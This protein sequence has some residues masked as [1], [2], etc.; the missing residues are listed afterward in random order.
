MTSPYILV[1]AASIT[2]AEPYIAEITNRGGKIQ[3]ALPDT[4]TSTTALLSQ[5]NALLLTGSEDIDPTMHGTTLSSVTDLDL[6]RERDNFEVLLISNALELDLP[7]LGI[8][9][10]MLLLNLAMGGSLLHEIPGHRGE[11]V[12]T[13]WHP[14]NH[15]VYLSPG[16]KLAAILGSGGFM[17]LNSL[18]HQG[19][20]EA[21]KAPKLL[22]TAYSL[23]DGIIEGLESPFH[24]W[25]IG[26]QCHPE[27]ANEVPG[28]FK[29]LF[30][31][32]VERSQSGQ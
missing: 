1:S 2:A 31:A 20:R 15:M 27:R 4:S 3:L 23:E 8:C 14:E 28:A 17:R 25:V 12:D 18:H 9:R 6:N 11:W 29:R 5:A 13:A 22:A 21:Q 7:I 10:G 26:L 32:F 16:C 24:T 19:L 30:Q